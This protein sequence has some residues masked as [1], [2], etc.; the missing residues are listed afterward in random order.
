MTCWFYHTLRKYPSSN[1]SIEQKFTFILLPSLI[2]FDS[3]W[4]FVHNR[5]FILVLYFRSA[6]PLNVPRELDVCWTTRCYLSSH[7]SLYIA[8][9]LVRSFRVHSLNI[10]KLIF[11]HFR[12]SVYHALRQNVRKFLT[13]Y[14]PKI[15]IL[16][17]VWLCALTLATWEKC[18]ELSDPTF[19][20]FV[21]TNYR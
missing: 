9:V 21:D 14:L 20:H 17:P 19:I 4:S 8:A 16:S 18:S 7:L 3:E 6:I 15:L 5:R 13:F 11:I 2:L 12:V 1:W 10:L